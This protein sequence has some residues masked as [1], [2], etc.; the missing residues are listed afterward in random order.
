MKYLLY[1]ILLIIPGASLYSQSVNTSTPVIADSLQK[2]IQRTVSDRILGF[3][4]DH[5]PDIKPEDKEVEFNGQ[6]L[7]KLASRVLLGEASDPMAMLVLDV[8]PW[9]VGHPWPDYYLV[10]KKGNRFI[11]ESNDMAKFPVKDTL[12]FQQYDQYNKYFPDDDRF[13][14]YYDRKEKRLINISGNF[15]QD[16]IYNSWYHVNNLEI[17]TLRFAQYNAISPYRAIWV[18]DTVYYLM[19]RCEFIK[20][21][22]GKFVIKTML[23]A[24]LDHWEI[25]YYSNKKEITGDP[26]K[27]HFY[28][29][30]F[31]RK[32]QTV[33]T[34]P[35]EKFSLKPMLRLVEKKERDE[36]EKFYGKPI[37]VFGDI[38][39]TAFD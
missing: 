26:D 25:I 38:D 2:F 24:S 14:V 22:P 5:I 39:M 1:I 33:G 32:L 30:K 21:I 6:I 31:I 10:S 17:P 4:V 18:K 15:R 8:Q 23:P 13:L 7:K 36:L 16:G 9:P 29:V 3:R 19:D 27:M 35:E 20:G 37:F 11:V 28:E 12:P 34:L